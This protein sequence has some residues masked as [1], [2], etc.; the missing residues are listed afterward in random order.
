MTDVEADDIGSG[1]L[2][3]SV[4]RFLRGKGDIHGGGVVSG[5]MSVLGFL[6]LHYVDYAIQ[7]QDYSEARVLSMV[8]VESQDTGV[9]AWVRVSCKEKS[10]HMLRLRREFGFN[11]DGECAIQFQDYSEARVISKVIVEFQPTGPS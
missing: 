8:M 1:R 5:N 9:C 10:M 7:F 6:L 11:S 2:S 3:D 4:P